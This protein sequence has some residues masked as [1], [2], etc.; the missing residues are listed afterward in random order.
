MTD[1]QPQELEK[2][3]PSMLDGSDSE[4]PDE[5]VFSDNHICEAGRLLV[6]DQV[7]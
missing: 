1:V 7:T 4:V 3:Q 6:L 5:L 2:T